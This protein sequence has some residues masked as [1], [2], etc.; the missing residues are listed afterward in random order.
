MCKDELGEKIDKAVFPGLQG[1]PHNHTTAGIAVALGEALK[2]E[3][4]EYAKQIVLNAKTLASEMINLGY[5]VVSGGTDNHLFL[6]DTVKSVN[7]SGGEASDILEKVNITLN[8]NAVPNDPRKPW[9]PSGIRIGT[10]AITTRGMKEADMKTIAH[11]IDDAL[12]NNADLVDIKSKVKEFAE[13][14]PI[15]GIDH[16]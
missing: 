6:V 14:F 11:F 3:F 9:D 13:K 12:K 2:P 4:K 7:L 5:S 8:K 16:I 10:P 15:P 1:G